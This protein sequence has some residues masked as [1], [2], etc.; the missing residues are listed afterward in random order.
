MPTRMTR[1]ALLGRRVR[2]YLA[3]RL[4]WVDVKIDAQ[5]GRVLVRG[6]VPSLSMRNRC[7]DCCRMVAGVL[8]VV[9]RLRVVN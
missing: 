8:H 2:R 1:D 4:P 9:D 3:Q 6:A 5:A 7:L